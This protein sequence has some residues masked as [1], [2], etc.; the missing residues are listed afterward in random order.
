MFYEQDAEGRREIRSPLRPYMLTPLGEHHHAV[1]FTN[2][3]TADEYKQVATLLAPHPTVELRVYDSMDQS[4]RNLDFLQ[5]FPAVRYFAA[6]SLSTRLE[7][8]DGLGYL[9]NLR[10]LTLDKPTNTLSLAALRHLPHLNDL[11]LNGPVRDLEVLAELTHLQVLT[12]RSLTLPDLAILA[13]LTRLWRLTLEYGGTNDLDGLSE[14]QGLQQL[15]L[16]RV[17]ALS[18]LSPISD[19][20]NLQFLSLT[21]QQ[22]VTQLPYLSKLTQLETIHLGNLRGLTDLRPLLTAPALRYLA[23]EGRHLEPDHIKPLSQHRTL[24]HAGIDLSSI[25]KSQAAYSLLRVKSLEAID[26]PPREVART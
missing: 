10:G 8:I 9:Q 11:Y 3:L 12:L 14:I 25:K 19:A 21:D 4:I 1:Q 5:H 13:T 22:Q 16:S 7:S 15:E 24:T 20:I 6:D 2:A 26:P 23:V 17:R 18:N